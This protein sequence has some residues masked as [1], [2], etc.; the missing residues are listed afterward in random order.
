MSNFDITRTVKRERD[1]R[2]D[3][4]T[5]EWISGHLCR[6]VRRSGKYFIQGLMVV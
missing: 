2:T 4:R 1:G 5:D 6:K 3:E